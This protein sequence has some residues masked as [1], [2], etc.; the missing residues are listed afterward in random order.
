MVATSPYSIVINVFSRKFF[1]TIKPNKISL[2]LLMSLLVLDSNRLVA[3]D[4]LAEDHLSR[5]PRFQKGYE[6][7]P[8]GYGIA[9][10]KLEVQHGLRVISESECDDQTLWR[11]DCVLNALKLQSSD[12]TLIDADLRLQL[13]SLWRPIIESLEANTFPQA[14]AARFVENMPAARVSVFAYCADITP[15]AAAAYLAGQDDC[16]LMRSRIASEKPIEALEAV[17]ECYAL[18]EKVYQ[19]LH[20]QPTTSQAAIKAVAS[21]GSFEAE[22]ARFTAIMT[23]TGHLFNGPYTPKDLNDKKQVATTNIIVQRCLFD[24]WTALDEA[25]AYFSSAPLIPAALV[26][27]GIKQRITHKRIVA[28]A[29]TFSPEI[30]V[31]TTGDYKRI[32]ALHG[33]VSCDGLFSPSRASFLTGQAYFCA[34]LTANNNPVER[35]N[36]LSKAYH[37]LPKEFNFIDAEDRP[38]S[39]LLSRAK[40]EL[41]TYVI[42]LANNLTEGNEGHNDPDYAARLLATRPTAKVSGIIS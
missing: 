23:A 40:D 26:D 41:R 6:R 16:Y 13:C 28:I 12:P 32:W 38:P 11:V 9:A 30:F 14:V 21:D 31:A 2:V 15:L 25:E 19:N 22:K 39:E 24:L 34:F 17:R 29:E 10:F 8:G 1:N 27:I 5:F 18:W 35:F 20:D 37:Y 36:F 3:T 4:N 42:G 33:D 7:P